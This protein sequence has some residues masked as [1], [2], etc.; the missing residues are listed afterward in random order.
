[1]DKNIH[2]KQYQKIIPN[3]KYKYHKVMVDSGLHNIIEWQI[4]D[5]KECKY[6]S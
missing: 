4:L 1:M 5:I 6:I 3:I 2:L